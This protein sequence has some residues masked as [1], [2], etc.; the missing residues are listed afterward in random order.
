MS[1]YDF[2]KFY[3]KPEDLRGSTHTVKI[4]SVYPG[5]F[6]NP[7]TRKEESKLVLMFEGK[8]KEMVLNATQAGEMMAITGTEHERQWIGAEIVLSAGAGFNGKQTIRISGIEKAKNIPV[9][10]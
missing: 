6:Y 7:K 4:S 1:A 3:L 10:V 5:K 9:A 2:Y 8:K